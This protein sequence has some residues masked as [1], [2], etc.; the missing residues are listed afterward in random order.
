MPNRALVYDYYHF[1]IRGESHSVMFYSA[2][3]IIV[4]LNCLALIAHQF[5]VRIYA[6]CFME[7]HFHVVI[8]CRKKD[9]VNFIQSFRIS[10]TKNVRKE[11]GSCGRLGS[12]DYQCNLIE[13]E[14]ML[15]DK[16]A[17]CVRNP[18][19]HGIMD[20]IWAYKWSSIRLYFASFEEL[21]KKSDIVT[22]PKFIESR[23]PRKRTLPQGWFMNSLGLILPQCYL[24][25]SV[26]IS[27]FSSREEFAE[28][29]TH[30]TQTELSN[31][32]DKPEDDIVPSVV[33]HTYDEIIGSVKNLCSSVLNVSKPIEMLTKAEKFLVAD[34]L[35]DN[36][37]VDNAMQI[38]NVVGI[39]RTSLYR[40]FKGKD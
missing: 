18:K 1:F 9:L 37:L 13:T 24:D 32:P 11:Q 38:C 40:H 14:E 15:V 33:K 30:P 39:P 22:D 28:F 10:L 34:F 8:R 3:E 27:N 31:N 23:L 35:W 6:F 16:I 4:A 7:N 17:Y 2:R 20:D 12:R 26:V 19:K 25:T 29:L 21:M 36:K 5:G